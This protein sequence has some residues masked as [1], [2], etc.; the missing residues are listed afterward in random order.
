M[1][2]SADIQKATQRV[3]RGTDILSAGAKVKQAAHAAITTDTTE[4]L[5]AAGYRLFQLDATAL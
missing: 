3:R 4:Q 1:P 2:S 5:Q